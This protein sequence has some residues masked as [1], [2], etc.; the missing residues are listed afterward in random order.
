MAASETNIDAAQDNLAPANISGSLDQQQAATTSTGESRTPRTLYALKRGDLFVVAD[1][2]GDIVGEGDGLFLNDTRLLS[3][4]R[5]RLAGRAPSL[6]S[7]RVSADNNIFSSHLTNRPL[8]P[9]GATHFPEG[10]VHIERQ[11]V[12]GA[13]QMHERIALTN[14]A[15]T[16]ICLPLELEVDADFRDM[17][18]VRGMTRAVRGRSRPPQAKENSIVFAY[19]GLDGVTRR[20]VVFASQPIAAFDGRIAQLPVALERGETAILHLEV[21]SGRAVWPSE[22]RWRQA[23]ARARRAVRATL[24]TGAS[25][26]AGNPVFDEWLSKSRADLALLRTE[27]DTGP[28]PYAGIPWFSTPFGRDGL[29]TAMQTLWLDPSLAR[30][31]L[32]FLAETQATETSAFRDSAPGKIMHETRRGEMADLGEIPFGRYYGGVDSTPLFIMLA[33][34]YA[35]RTGELSFIEEIWPALERAV[36]WIDGAGASDRDGFVGYARG[37]GTGLANQG[38][39]DSSDSVFH[40]DGSDPAGPIALVEVQGYVFAALRAM[41]DMAELRGDA[42]SASLY[43]RRAE[44]MRAAIE[45]CFWME[46]SSFY[47]LARDGQRRLCAVRASNAAHLLFVGAPSRRRARG[48]IDALLGAP[49]LSGWGVRTLAMGEARYNPLSYHN[50]SVWPHDTAIAAAGMARYGER[51]GVVRIMSG[52]FE[53]AIRFDMRLPELFCGIERRGVGDA[54]VAYPVAC[55]P[56]AW[57]AGSAFMLLQACLGVTVDHRRGLRVR[58][59]RLP[60]GVDLITIGDLDVGG[61]KHTLTFQRVGPKVAVFSDRHFNGAVPLVTG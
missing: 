39:K 7:A 41:G 16:R 27:L 42:P 35:H 58:Q 45:R 23:C 4:F 6:L 22:T 9:I 33:G 24:H 57:A 5:I 15:A 26:R 55:V 28:Y 21:G 32:A 20:S 18:E 37:L 47:A 17:F 3:C 52:V 1:S 19:E 51:D 36:G 30:G 13:G 49:F 40:A 43:R 38:W 61:E 14:F 60:A 48:V 34:A 54:P 2:H 29:I 12:L 8:P 25:L 31:V 10:V 46:E 59:P 44:A 50:G 53:A 56:Q 11:R